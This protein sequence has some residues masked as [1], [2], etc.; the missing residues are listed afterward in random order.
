MKKITFMLS[1]VLG[2]LGYAQSTLG[3]YTEATV[4][5][6]VVTQNL[7][8]DGV[9]INATF[10]DAGTD[11]GSNV[12]EVAGNPEGASNY[13]G[14]FNYPGSPNQ[15]LSSYSYY[16]FSMK[17]SS[18][19]PTIIRFE[20][21]GGQ[22]ANFDPTN[23]GFSYDGNWYTMVIPF[24]DITSQNSNFDFTDVNNVFFVKSTP[25]DAGSVVPETYI[26]YIDH[27]YFST[28]SNALST[29]SFEFTK[30]QMF[31]NPAHS[32]I[33]INTST[34]LDAINIYNVLGKEVLAAQTKTLQPTLDISHLK[35]GIYIVKLTANGKTTSTK[36]IKA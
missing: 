15:D 4:T 14:Y 6:T 31:P 10:A 11:G 19:Q 28:E 3:Y 8:G 24:T 26:F 32:E 13:Q 9:T 36:L 1:L 5:E 27:V 7:N 34:Q 2:T 18:P 21:A 35:S 16:H 20:D 30:I 33:T 29:E 25:G 23:Y 12:I 22:Q 17:S